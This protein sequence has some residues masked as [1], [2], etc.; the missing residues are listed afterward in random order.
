VFQSAVPVAKVVQGIHNSE[1]VLSAI[2]RELV[3]KTEQIR[4]LVLC[5]GTAHMPRER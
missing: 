5:A 2:Q 4:S 1:Y 3:W